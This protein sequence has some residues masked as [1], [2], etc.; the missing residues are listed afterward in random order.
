MPNPHLV[1]DLF[2]KMNMGLC[3]INSFTTFTNGGYHHLH[4]IHFVNFA[5][6][7]PHFLHKDFILSHK[8]YEILSRP[9]FSSWWNKRSVLSF[10][11]F[12]KYI[13]TPSSDSKIF[14]MMYVLSERFP[15]SMMRTFSPCLNVGI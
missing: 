7:Q 6:S 2:I 9:V 3:I 14:F 8:F 12:K 4:F 10:S 1:T 15:P 11:D 5:V 13:D